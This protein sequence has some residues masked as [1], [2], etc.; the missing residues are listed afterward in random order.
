M[1]ISKDNVYS[2]TLSRIQISLTSAALNLK[3][4]TQA[5]SYLQWTM[6]GPASTGLAA[7]DFFTKLRTG[8]G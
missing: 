3:F 6:I 2:P 1:T 5:G 7:D 8:N 4:A